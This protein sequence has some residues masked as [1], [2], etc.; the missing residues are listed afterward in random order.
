[1]NIYKGYFKLNLMGEIKLGTYKHYKGDFYEII[2]LAKHS[3]TKEELVIYRSLKD[4]VLWARPKGMFL[5]KIIIDEKETPRFTFI[6][7]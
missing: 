1:M 5:E 4:K 6:G 7:N 3:E 2:G